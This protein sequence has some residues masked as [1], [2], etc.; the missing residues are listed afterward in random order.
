MTAKGQR[1]VWESRNEDLKTLAPSRLH[2]QIREEFHPSQ[3]PSFYEK[4]ESVVKK[5]NR[6]HRKRRAGARRPVMSKTEKEM[7]LNDIEMREA[8][9][10][11]AETELAQF[12]LEISLAAR[13]IRAIRQNGK[14]C[15][16]VPAN[17]RE[18]F[19]RF[20]EVYI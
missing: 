19:D 7:F 10:R 8:E 11:D 6:P 17:I 14:L 2:R 20:A 5:L 4:P 18:E 1:H 16:L 15:R 9:L 12:K 3:H 13:I